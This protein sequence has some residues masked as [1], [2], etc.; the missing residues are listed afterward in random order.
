MTK[1]DLGVL[2][3]SVVWGPVLGASGE[4]QGEAL[5]AGSLRL[6]SLCGLSCRVNK[7][8]PGGSRPT[9]AQL[10][11]LMRVREGSSRRSR[12][13]SSAGDWLRARRASS[14]RC[15]PL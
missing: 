9:G 13:P 3:S 7:V 6:T 4:G 1:E 15:S 5:G 8:H 11:S 10:A 14:G 2:S 12:S